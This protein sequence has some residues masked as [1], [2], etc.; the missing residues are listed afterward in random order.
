[1]NPAPIFDCF[2]AYQKTA[3]MQAS[4]DI[5]LFSAIASGA[6]TAPAIAKACDASP[7][8]VRVLC[9][10]WTV[11]GFLIKA[12]GGSYRLTPEAATFLD[13][14]SPAYVGGAIG[15]LNGAVAPFFAR[16]TQ[17]VRHGG[18]ETTGSVDPD[19]DGWVPFA[20]GMGAMM[21]PTAHA[22]AKILGPIPAGGRVLDVAASHGLFGIVLAQQNPGVRVTA[23]DWPN[24]L[25]VATQNAARL[26]VGDRHTTLPGDA[27]TAD[28]QG[29]Y[30]VILLTNLLHHFSEAQCISLLKRL[31]AALKP[32]GQ[33][34]TLEFVPNADRVS[35]PM[36]ATFPLVMLGTTAHGDAYT[37][38]ELDR[39]LRA[40]GFA[41]N[42]LHQPEESPQ[43]VIVST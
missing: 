16:L 2:T 41:D 33:L 11:Q 4:I 15:F 14:A 20:Q 22:I 7:K 26:S 39:M 24:V 36:S 1:M 27:F 3:A 25:E 13:R 42:Q 21:F 28:L 34:V 10:Y 32:G 31:R 8:G 30:D 6:S 5:G 35:P 17:A 38:A 19:Y 23:L 43:Q 37:F 9:D 40:A 12:N 18:C 29:P